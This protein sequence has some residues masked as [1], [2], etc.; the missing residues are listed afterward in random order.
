VAE[1]VEQFPRTDA[2]EFTGHTRTL[3]DGCFRASHTQASSS[4]GRMQIAPPCASTHRH[5]L[6]ATTTY[7]RM[8]VA[9]LLEM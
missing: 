2:P 6:V 1:L 7:G 3:G 4:R 9:P 5:S 8:R